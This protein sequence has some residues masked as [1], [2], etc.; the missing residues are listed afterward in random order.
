MCSSHLCVVSPQPSGGPLPPLTHL[1]LSL[2]QS[3]SV[4]WS[5]PLMPGT[6]PSLT[7]KSQPPS[8]LKTLPIWWGKRTLNHH[9][10]RS[11]SFIVLW[12]FWHHLPVPGQAPGAPGGRQRLAP[13][14]L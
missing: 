3:V 5:S 9:S 10:I 13:A 8:L 14:C 4:F 12:A 1:F 11:S 7:G 2:E 6:W